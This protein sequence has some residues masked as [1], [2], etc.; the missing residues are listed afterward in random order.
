MKDAMLV[1]RAVEAV[2]LFLVGCLT[3]RAIRIVRLRQRA[4][5]IVRKKDSKSLR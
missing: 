3:V 4:R 5:E 1:M 2:L